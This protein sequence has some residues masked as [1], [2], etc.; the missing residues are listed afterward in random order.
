MHADANST[1]ILAAVLSVAIS[2]VLFA[3]AIVPASPGL[4]A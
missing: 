3:G 1:T 4:F 2:A